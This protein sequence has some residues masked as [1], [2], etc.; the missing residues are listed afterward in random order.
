MGYADKRV[1]LAD[2]IVDV[3]NS[4]RSKFRFGS[5]QKAGFR[6]RIEVSAQIL[7]HTPVQTADLTAFHPDFENGAMTRPMISQTSRYDASI[8]GSKN[9]V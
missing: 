6:R 7:T 4:S 1:R 8:K 9:I 2:I 3:N 5:L